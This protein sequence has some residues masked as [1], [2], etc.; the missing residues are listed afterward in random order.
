MHPVIRVWIQQNLF[1]M[2]ESLFPNTKC[3]VYFSEFCMWL[4][5][6][7]FAAGHHLRRRWNKCKYLIICCVYFSIIQDKYASFHDSIFLAFWHHYWQDSLLCVILIKRVLQVAHLSSFTTFSI[8]RCFV[9]FLFR[10]ILYENLRS[11]CLIAEAKWMIGRIVT[12][13]K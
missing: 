12:S 10:Y 2:N 4:A 13:H 7:L 3:D 8:L 6:E 1:N 9:S 5:K 11:T